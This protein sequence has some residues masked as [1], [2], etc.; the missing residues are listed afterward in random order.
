[1]YKIIIKVLVRKSQVEKERYVF[2]LGAVDSAQFNESMDDIADLIYDADL[3]FAD[4]DGDMILDDILVKI[5]EQESFRETL[6]GKNY[7][8]EIIA[9]IG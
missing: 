1:M 3:E 2:E 7:V 8:Y 6:K 4:E 9:E 5:S